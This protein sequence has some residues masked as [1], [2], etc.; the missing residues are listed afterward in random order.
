MMIIATIAVLWALMGIEPV[1]PACKP[2]PLPVDPIRLQEMKGAE[3]VISDESTST[4]TVLFNNGDVLRLRANPSVCESRLVLSARLW[5]YRTIDPYANSKSIAELLL[6]ASI[7]KEIDQSISGTKETWIP[8][9]GFRLE[10]QT[11]SQIIWQVF[12][13]S[14]QGLDGMGEMI[15][16]SFLFPAGVDEPLQ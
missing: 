1:Q 14:P 16:I 6:P 13:S 3:K 11:R 4:V 2:R 8:G 12:E 7:S 5:T 15:A 9:H 10:G